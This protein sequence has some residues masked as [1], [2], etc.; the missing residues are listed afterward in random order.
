MKN[1][2]W[3]TIILAGGSGERLWPLSRQLLPK[4]LLPFNDNSSLLAMTLD[5]IA[6]LVAKE[7]RWI[8]T[9]GL[10]EPSITKAVGDKVE[11]ILAEPAARNTAP[12]IAWACLKLYQ[13]DPDAVALFLSADHYIPDQHLFLSDI[14]KAAQ[15]AQQNDAITLLGIKPTS[16]A[17]GYG[18]IEYIHSDS[19]ELHTVK[20]FHE[21]P[22]PEKANLYL[23]KN[24]ML[25]NTGIFCGTIRTFIK[26]FEIHAPEL[27][28]HVKHFM[29]G[30][31]EYEAIEKIS[32]DNAVMEKSNV[33]SVLPATFA[34]SDV[35]NLDV[36]LSLQDQTQEA[37]KFVSTL[38]AHNNL[39][40]STSQKHVALIGVDDLCV[41]ETHDA[42]LITKRADVEKVKTILQQIR[43]AEK[44]ELL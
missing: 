4:Q 18:Y 29:D 15:H 21:K 35:G 28:A 43:S 2:H 32:F 5:R 38:D 30:T 14:A 13:H 16:A 11:T 9:T 42:L 10:Q 7:R 33:T 6:P 39:V 37:N 25:W 41:V 23:A 27:L 24:N 26:E 3:Y 20:N 19:Q 31:I 34:W 8:I 17:T 1:E 40:H 44:T 12:A 22:S 36:F